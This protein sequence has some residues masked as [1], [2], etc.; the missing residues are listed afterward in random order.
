MWVL[1]VVTCAY[2]YSAPLFTLWAGTILVK[3]HVLLPSSSLMPRSRGSA[4]SSL[5]A[6][7]P[8]LLSG[9]IVGIVF[10]AIYGHDLKSLACKFLVIDGSFTVI[11]SNSGVMT[12]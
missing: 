5:F 6:L 9:V 1:V 8:S 12:T 3:G 7:P 4:C 2:I 11:P 10:T